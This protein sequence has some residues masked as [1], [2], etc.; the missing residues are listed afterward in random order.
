MKV[1]LIWWSEFE[2]HEYEEI[3]NDTMEQLREF[4]QFLERSVSGD[5]TLVDEF[6]SVQLAIQ[7]AVSEAFRTPEVIRMFAEKQ[8]DRLRSRLSDLAVSPSSP[9][10]FLICF[11]FSVISN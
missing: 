6:G 3:R 1:I 8:P 7:A 9:K 5:L 2:A 11:H 4:Q 10:H